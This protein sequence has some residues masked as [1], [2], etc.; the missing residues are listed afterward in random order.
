MWRVVEQGQVLD[1]NASLDEEARNRAIGFAANR[2]NLWEHQVEVGPVY[3]NIEL[4]SARSYGRVLGYASNVVVADLFLGSVRVK[5]GLRSEGRYGVNE[6]IGNSLF[7]ALGRRW[8]S[9]RHRRHHC[10]H[11]NDRRVRSTLAQTGTYRCASV[12]YGQ[13]RRNSGS[14]G[15]GRTA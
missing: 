2:L 6:A 11:R 15:I 13:G 1:R 9:E 12:H 4:G 14:A 10:D 3:L 8:R 5:I 7:G